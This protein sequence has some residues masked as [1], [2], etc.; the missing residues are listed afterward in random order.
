[1]N[2][3]AIGTYVVLVHYA[4]IDKYIICS[5]F[6]KTETVSGDL[7]KAREIFDRFTADLEKQSQLE[8]LSDMSDHLT[9]SQWDARDA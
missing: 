9:M 1:M 7:T 8:K 6:G 3:L 5:C 4:P 2:V